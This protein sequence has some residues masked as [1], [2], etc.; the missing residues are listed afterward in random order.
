M[1]IILEGPWPAPSVATT[2][3]NPKFSDTENHN[4]SVNRQ[5]SMNGV[6]YSYVKDESTTL[7]TY[8]FTLSRMKSLELQAFIKAFIGYQ[9]RLTDH[10]AQKWLVIFNNNPAEVTQ[11]SRAVGPTGTEYDT[12]TLTLLGAL[13]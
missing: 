8:T 11:A 10:K 4:V 1:S 12:V 3:P 9:I 13:A 6:L 2:L 7:L 5:R